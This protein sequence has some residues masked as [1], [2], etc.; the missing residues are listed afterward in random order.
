MVLLPE[1]LGPMIAQKAPAS[2]ETV[3][4]ARA[5]IT[6]NGSDSTSYT[7]SVKDTDGQAVAANTA[8]TV[9]TTAG[10]LTSGG[11]PLTYTV[12]YTDANG[13]IVRTLYSS[14]VLETATITATKTRKPKHSTFIPLAARL[15][16]ASMRRSLRFASRIGNVSSP[17]RHPRR[18][19]PSSPIDV[20]RSRRSVVADVK[21]VVI[22]VPSAGSRLAPW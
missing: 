16:I 18:S 20:A 6:A 9:T 1:P 19:G 15:A 22:V 11:S 3:T 2:N 10:S 21:D 17:H 12:Y 13:N 5:Q 8:V 4:P 7:I 14:G